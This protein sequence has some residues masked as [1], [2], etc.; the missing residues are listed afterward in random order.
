MIIQYNMDDNT[1]QYDPPQWVKCVTNWKISNECRKIFL[2][3]LIK[4]QIEG[5]F[6]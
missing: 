4:S 6:N 5:L 2:H 1:R 3:L